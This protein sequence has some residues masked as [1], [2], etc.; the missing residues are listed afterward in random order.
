MIVVK[1]TILIM[2]YFDS[3]PEVKDIE[4]G[5]CFMIPVNHDP[6]PN[7]IDHTPLLINA[8]VLVK[9]EWNRPS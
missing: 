9:G 6:D 3:F 1:L 2:F 8:P 7:P 5:S 4:K